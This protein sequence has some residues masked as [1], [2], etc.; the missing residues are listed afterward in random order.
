M[1]WEDSTRRLA[2]SG[3]PLSLINFWAIFPL[4]GWYPFI[5][6]KGLEMATAKVCKV[7]DSNI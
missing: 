6:V 3:S 2:L 1:V 7:C 4:S 5:V